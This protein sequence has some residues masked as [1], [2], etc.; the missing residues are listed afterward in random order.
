MKAT[1]ANMSPLQA[2]LDEAHSYRIPPYQRRY[3]W[4][5][6]RVEE[7]WEDVVEMYEDSDHKK[8]EYLLGS[9]VTVSNNDG[10]ED[11]VDGQQRLVSLTLMFCALRDSLNHYLAMSDGDLKSELKSMIKGIDDHIRDGRN[12][13]IELNNR[14]DALLLDAICRADP[15]SG[16]L[17]LQAGKALRENYDELLRSSKYLCERIDILKPDLA[18]TDKLKEMLKSM[19][20]R[21]FVVYIAVTN[22]SDAQQIF[23]TLNSTGQPLTESDLIKNYLVLKNTSGQNV[24]GNWK[25]VF[26]PFA[27]KIRNSPKKS[28]TYI[29]DSLM[30]RN[31][32]IKKPG[33]SKDVG[34]RELYKA[35][36]E[37]LK[38]GYT[39]ME[40]INDLG[41]DIDIINVLENPQQADQHL[42]HSLYGLKQIHAVYFRRP[43]IAAVR[44]WGWESHKTF[45]L[46][47]CLLKFFFMYRTVCKM[48]VDKIRSV[49]RDIT[50][51]INQRND[52]EIA[53]LYK[54]VSDKIHDMG[55]FHS[56]FHSKFVEEAYP[57]D[58]TKY[59]LI[60]IERE[61]HKELKG[62][63]FQTNF[64]IEHVFPQKH[65]QEAWSNYAELEPYMDNI[66][67]LT[68]LPTK[69]NK[70]LQNYAFRVKKMG[71]KDNGNIV[72]L[73]GKNGRDK[74]GKQ[75][76][77]SYET[78]NIKLNKY[79]QDCDKWDKKE[80]LRRQKAL[81][82]HA[83]KIWNLEDCFKR[84][85]AN[86]DWGD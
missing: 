28:D 57:K 6:A 46:V 52:T 77:I 26:A 7:L 32:Q 48:D 56:Q 67:N 80:L 3:T 25:Q 2:V 79:F 10:T 45:G 23:Q 1:S 20:S 66:G 41:V 9:I 82:E 29:Y 74:K 85:G 75:I 73:S 11:V 19:T 18:G 83:N 38:G 16:D 15:S 21:V 35:V 59:I 27:R 58:V 34:K 78:S 50:R 76:K 8:D 33:G 62:S 37:K 39:V 86:S 61:L 68:L 13:F 60:S 53:D 4:E 40:F 63:D 17:R 51:V 30:S 69:W 44:K 84:T 81:Q 72:T 70:V 64:D 12:T 24:E 31:Y 42:R 65:K 47:D 54:I 49:A 43:I 14:E 22:E 36:K 71:V 5:V 55:E